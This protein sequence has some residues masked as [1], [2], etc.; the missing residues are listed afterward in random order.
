MGNKKVK[1][2][3]ISGAPDQNID[4]LND[5]IDKSSFII[6]AD[7]GYLTC[8]SANIRPNLIMGDFDSSDFP[9]ADCEVISF[10]PIKDDTDTLCCVKEAIKRGADE[11][12]I[13]CGIGS[14]LDHTY[15]NLLCLE[16]CRK[17][18]VNAYLINENNKASIVD[19][20][21]IIEKSEYKYFSLFAFLGD[22]SGLSIQGAAYELDNK[23]IY[24]GNLFG[25]SNEFKDDIVKITVKKGL[26]LLILSND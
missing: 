16:Y 24:A 18:N 6:A 14:R 9:Q 3:I 8:L 17:H 21:I 15:A 25:Q 10:S 1:F 26:I 11:I 4:F 2:T 19:R 23:Y 7:S 5:K 20:E 12:E 22:V 13:Y